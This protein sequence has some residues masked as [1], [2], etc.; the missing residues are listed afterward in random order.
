MDQPDRWTAQLPTICI[1]GAQ[2]LTLVAVV[3]L[4]LTGKPDAGSD[5]SAAA[6]HSID[7]TAT[8]AAEAR[9]TMTSNP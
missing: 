9:Q 4:M 2:F 3:A 6:S 5:Q 7:G 1:L 8:A